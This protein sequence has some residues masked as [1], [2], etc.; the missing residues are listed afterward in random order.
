[1]R[2][3]AHP[4]SL[5]TYNPTTR[6]CERTLQACPV[7]PLT[8]LDPTV[9]SYEDGAID[10]ANEMQN[11]R[12]GA[13]CLVR[14]ARS[15]HLN[16]TITSGSRPDAYQAHLRE[17]YDQWQLLKDNND[18]QCADVKSQAQA[19]YSKHGPFA[20]QPA[21]TSRHSSG[22]AVDVHLS[23]YTNAD[24]IVAGCNMSRPVSPDAVHFESPR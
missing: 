5:Y 12:D 9:Q 11:T 14:E 7:A 8:P 20:H 1:M 15:Q 4:T 17:V 16:P 22:R 18:P 2:P 23:D 24:T 6:M 10:I 19:E 21:R 13:G 3:F